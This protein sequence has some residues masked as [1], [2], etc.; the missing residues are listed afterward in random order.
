MDV[1]AAEGA[2]FIRGCRRSYKRRRK[3]VTRIVGRVERS[4]THQSLAGLTMGIATL[5]PSYAC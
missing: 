2:I 1:G 5:N 3:P 4:D